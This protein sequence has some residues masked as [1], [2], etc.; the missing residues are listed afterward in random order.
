MLEKI[1]TTC[2][3]GQQI[4]ILFSFIWSVQLPVLMSWLA[5][6]MKFT[7]DTLYALFICFD[8]DRIN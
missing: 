5:Y 2:A 1:I 7:K 4:K 3:E 8:G 6:D